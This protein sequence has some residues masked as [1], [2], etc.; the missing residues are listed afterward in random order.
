MEYP[1][2]TC[3]NFNDK[4]TSKCLIWFNH[5]HNVFNIFYTLWISFT[6]STKPRMPN[7]LSK[8]TLEDGIVY[9]RKTAISSKQFPYHYSIV[10]AR[11]CTATAIW[12]CRK[13][14]SQ[15]KRS[16]H[17]KRCSHW[18]KGLRQR[19]IAVVGPC[20]SQHQT[21]TSD[22][23]KMAVIQ[24]I[25]D[26]SRWLTTKQLKK[27][28]PLHALC[29]RACYGCLLVSLKSEWCFKFLSCSMEYSS[30]TLG[31][32]ILKVFSIVIDNFGKIVFKGNT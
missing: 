12:R 22:R 3:Q 10:T 7:Y 31:R 11:S 9:E 32:D 29:L 20:V 18:L 28:A 23:S 5:N 27:T 8:N 21:N 26:I 24:F 25:L 1:A 6:R 2:N 17:W 30:V 19:Q 4:E 15:W 14:F 16:F 13:P